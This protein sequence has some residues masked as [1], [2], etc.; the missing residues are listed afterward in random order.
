MVRIYECLCLCVSY[1][2]PASAIAL[3]LVQGCECLCMCVLHD[4]VPFSPP[5]SS[6]PSLYPPYP[7]THNAHTHTKQPSRLS[8][9]RKKRGHVSA[10]HGRIG[11][12]RKHPGKYMLDIGLGGVESCVGSAFLHVY[13]YTHYLS[14]TLTPSPKTKH[15][16][17]HTHTYTHRWSR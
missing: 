6:C 9:N 7:H 16:H 15:T 14:H 10:G 11:K 4:P 1:L 5:F 13:S 8:K 17:T 3:P 2:V 12:H